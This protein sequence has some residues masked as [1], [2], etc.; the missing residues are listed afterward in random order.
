MGQP[1]LLGRFRST[2]QLG[3]VSSASESFDILLQRLG[4]GGEA[5][6]GYERLRSRLTAF[7]RVRFPAQ[8]EALAD[9]ALDRLAR[10]LADGTVIDNLA[11]YALGIGRLL[12][13][14]EASRQQKIRSAAIETG[15]DLEGQTDPD[16]DLEPDPILPILQACLQSQGREAAFF[17]LEYYAADGGANRIERRQRLAETTGVSLNALRNRALRIRLSLEKC[18]RQHLQHRQAKS[19][20][21]DE[22]SKS[23]TL[24]MLRDDT[25]L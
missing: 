7:F 21:R 19:A 11:G 23:D 1:L 17:I 13:L 12:L 2:R 25:A 3:L 6:L 16:P 4:R 9:E 15:H 20:E 24:S 5:A 10:R 22:M 8:A 14:E 18:V